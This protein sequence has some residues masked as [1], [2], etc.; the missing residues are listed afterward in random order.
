[1]AARGHVTRNQRQSRAAISSGMSTIR[2]TIRWLMMAAADVLAPL[3]RAFRFICIFK[4]NFRKS[5]SVDEMNFLK[6]F[7]SFEKESVV[8]LTIFF[9]LF[10]LISRDNWIK[11]NY[12]QLNSIKFFFKKIRKNS[13][14]LCLTFLKLKQT[15]KS[16][17]L[18]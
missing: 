9:R 14:K 12:I 17:K 5:H 8:I 11:S 3:A 7:Y 18:D 10:E 1:M 2:Q 15:F 16:I 13:V 4:S 6:N